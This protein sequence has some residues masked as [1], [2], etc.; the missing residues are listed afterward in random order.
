MLYIIENK[1]SG[2]I[3]IGHSTHPEKRLR[4]LQ[5]GNDNTLMLLSTLEVEDSRKMEGLLH[6]MFQAFRKSGEWFLL[7][8]KHKRLLLVIFDKAQP[9]PEELAAITRLGFRAASNSNNIERENNEK[10]TTRNT[11]V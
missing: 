9:T 3:K 7:D 1:T 11:D 5:T 4:A 6:I 8:E 10:S 2:Q